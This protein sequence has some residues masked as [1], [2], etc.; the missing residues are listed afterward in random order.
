M[1]Y[2]LA[3]TFA[4]NHHCMLNNMLESDE[5]LSQNEIKHTVYSY[6]M[7]ANHTQPLSVIHG[8]QL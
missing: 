6:A 7:F 3:G 8:N 2:L 5:V 4:L 1:L